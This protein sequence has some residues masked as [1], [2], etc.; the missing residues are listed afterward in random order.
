[1]IVEDPNYCVV[2]NRR[3]RLVKKNL[4]LIFLLLFSL[5]DWFL[6]KDYKPRADA[7]NGRISGMPQLPSVNGVYNVLH[8]G[9]RNDG[10]ADA[11]I[12][13][14]RAID[15]ACNFT[16]RFASSAA[17]HAPAG[18]YRVEAPLWLHCSGLMFSGAGLYATSIVP[19]YDFGPTMVLVNGSY[20]NIQTERS[21]LVGRGNSMYLPGDT[22]IWLN[23]RTYNGSIRT[24]LGPGGMNV[25]GL[26]TFTAEL[27]FRPRSTRDGCLVCSSSMPSASRGYVSAFGIQ[28]NGGAYRGFLAVGGALR[29]IRGPAALIGHPVHLALTYDG[30]AVNFWVNG[31]KQSTGVATNGPIQQDMTEDVTIGTGLGSYWPD[32]AP[33]NAS[34]NGDLDSVRISN[35]VR[36]RANFAPPIAKFE[37]DSN[38]L[39]LTNFELA[40]EGPFVKAY[41][42]ARGIGWLFANRTRDPNGRVSYAHGV[43]R[44][45]LRDF[46]IAS[47]SPLASPSGIIVYS[48]HDDDMG[49][50]YFNSLELPLEIINIAFENSFHD[51]M[52]NACGRYGIVD[53]SVNNSFVYTR[54]TGGWACFVDAGGG[55]WFNPICQQEGITNYGLVIPPGG[56]GSTDLYS[57][58]WDV[59][60]SHSHFKAAIWGSGVHYLNVFGGQLGATDGSPILALD[61]GGKAT[62]VGTHLYGVP[63]P[64]EVVHIISAPKPKVI[65]VNPTFPGFTPVLSRTPGVVAIQ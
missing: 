34:V 5:S 15:D 56:G 33:L 21:L 8:Y 26:R 10:S 24:P 4:L 20:P 1:V 19:L 65:L 63:P 53:N 6:A 59:E 38:T 36:Y 48:N 2:R 61:G 44:V 35:S 23:L 7:S 50:V 13:I 17:V 64:A 14:Q 41:A 43:D 52:A 58:K 3:S 39:M 22:S 54:V 32:G 11:S 42:G 30:S 37:P 45:T 62:V 16:S 25:N 31:R 60:N 12:A 27:T 9:A 29:S 47:Y 57:P 28:I 46:Q 51:L 55:A 49:P 40:S 18:S